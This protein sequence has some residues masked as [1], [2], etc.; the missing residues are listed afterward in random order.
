MRTRE[1]IA[2]M[3]ESVR[4]APLTAIHHRSQQLSKSETSL[5][6]IL[7]KD[8]SMTPYKVQLVEE[9]KPIEHPMHFR[10][11]KWACDRLTE[12]ADFGKEKNLLFK[13]PPF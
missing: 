13:Y 7:Y 1:N 9:L 8:F 10:F 11:A 4:E 3:A 6:R 12:D 2:A 5:R